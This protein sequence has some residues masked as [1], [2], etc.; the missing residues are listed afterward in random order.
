MR[1]IFITWHTMWTT[2]P[3]NESG[4]INSYDFYYCNFYY[5]I[6]MLMPFV[7]EIFCRR[8][9]SCVIEGNA[10]ISWNAR[11]KFTGL[12]EFSAL[13]GQGRFRRSTARRSCVVFDEYGGAQNDE[14]HKY[15][16]HPIKFR[17]WLRSCD[18]ER[19][20]FCCLRLSISWPLDGSFHWTNQWNSSKHS[21]GMWARS[22]Y[23]E[24]AIC[25]LGNEFDMD[26]VS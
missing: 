8:L 23:D 15:K 21:N 13:T 25:V 3:T 14:K 9:G 20:M 11:D 2:T 16:T 17:Q 7:Y 4:R 6:V 19:R 5:Q 12:G 26:C 10:R 22:I 24:S 18:R 1:P